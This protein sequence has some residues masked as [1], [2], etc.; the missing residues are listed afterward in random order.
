ME[1][2]VP[3]NDMP[4]VEHI[5]SASV[6]QGEAKIHFENFDKICY[7]LHFPI[8]YDFRQC[9]EV[10]FIARKFEGNTEDRRKYSVFLVENSEWIKSFIS[11]SD[12]VYGY[13]E[14]EYLHY[15]I[16]D[17]IDTIIEIIA[18]KP[19]LFSMHP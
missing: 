6:L 8:V 13:N 16:Y 12:G 18:T 9:V 10:A 7:E 2:L 5:T 11:S 4:N 1:K 19:P 3:L 14:G 17:A 15:I